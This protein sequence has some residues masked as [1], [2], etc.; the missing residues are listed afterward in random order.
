MS[1]FKK[2]AACLI[3]AVTMASISISAIA[4]SWTIDYI[5]GAPSDV[6][7]NQFVRI[8]HSSNTMKWA[9]VYVEYINSGGKVELKTTG[10]N[11]NADSVTFTASAAPYFYILD[12]PDVDVSIEL[13]A[14]ANRVVSNGWV[15]FY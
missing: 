13:W 2:I 10:F 11:P 4:E 15:H 7:K 14:R 8:T 3:A 6:S 1:K 12:N 5:Y 9:G